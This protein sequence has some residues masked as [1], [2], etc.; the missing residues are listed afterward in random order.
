[1]VQ[2]KEGRFVKPSIVA[3]SFNDDTVNLGKLE[4]H[5]YIL[6]SNLQQYKSFFCHIGVKEEISFWDVFQYLKQLHVSQMTVIGS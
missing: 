3:C 5:L 6:P 4:P 1:M 2:V